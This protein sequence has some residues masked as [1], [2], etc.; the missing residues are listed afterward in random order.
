MRYAY[1]DYV[2]SSNVGRRREATERTSRADHFR[3]EGDAGLQWSSVT[4]WR[5]VMHIGWR[6]AVVRSRSHHEVMSVPEQRQTRWTADSTV[7]SVDLIPRTTLPRTIVYG[8]RSDGR[9]DIFNV[10]GRRCGIRRDNRRQRASACRSISGRMGTCGDERRST[11]DER[12]QVG[13]F[14]SHRAHDVRE[15]DLRPST[16]DLYISAYDG[17]RPSARYRQRRV[18]HREDWIIWTC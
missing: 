8:W 13:R 17:L 2:E 15:C 3:S 16:I 1:P 10:S 9:E 18:V 4:V 11:V 5:S 7:K 6:R 12:T 14:A